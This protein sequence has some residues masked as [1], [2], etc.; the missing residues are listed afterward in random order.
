MGKFIAGPSVIRLPGRP[1]V[2]PGEWFEYDY[3]PGH[4]ALALASGAI[5]LQPGEQTAAEKLAI[6]HAVK[7][8]AAHQAEAELG[9]IVAA[10]PVAAQVVEEPSAEAADEIE[11]DR[12]EPQSRRN[13]TD[14]A[15]E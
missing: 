15:K 3:Q 1:A 11:E 12:S 2:V 6:A 10:Q 13:S 7:L 9:A 8:E 4:E 14:D 5:T